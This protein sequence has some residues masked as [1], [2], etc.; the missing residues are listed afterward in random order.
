MRTLIRFGISGGLATATHVAVFVLLVEWLHIRPL[1][2]SVP[3][4]LTAVGVSYSMNYRW[5][6]EAVGPHHELL[7]RFMLVALTGLGLNLLITF[8]VVDVAHYWYG[9]ALM[10]ILAAVPLV[11]FSLSRFWVF[12]KA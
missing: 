10:T 5:T 7:P 8:L 6:F 4:F 2:A 12:N 3:A 1:Y 11:T 9:Y